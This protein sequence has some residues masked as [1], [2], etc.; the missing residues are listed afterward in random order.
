MFYILW[1]P[2]AFKR[3]MAKGH[4]CGNREKSWKMLNKGLI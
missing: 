1:W 4:F 2:V 3:G